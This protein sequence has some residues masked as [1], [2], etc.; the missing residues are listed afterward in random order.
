[1]RDYTRIAMPHDDHCPY[2]DCG[3]FVKD[4]Y[5]EWYPLPKQYEIGRR[6]L[7]MDCPWCRRPV[8]LEKRRPVLP[9]Q[10]VPMEARSYAEATKYAVIQPEIYLSLEAFLSD[11]NQ[12]E[13]AAPYKLGYWENVNI[14]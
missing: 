3:K 4:W 8:L 2:E 6:Q 9:T 7:A 10:K 5:I 14:P 11:P 1:M 12:V 13:K